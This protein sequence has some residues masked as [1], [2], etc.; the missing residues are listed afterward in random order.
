M[1]ELNKIVL[2]AVQKDVELYTD[3]PL[4]WKKIAGAMTVPRGCVWICNGESY[5]SGKRKRALL[6]ESKMYVMEKVRRRQK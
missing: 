3:M 6:I 1:D 2:F 4:G 5:F